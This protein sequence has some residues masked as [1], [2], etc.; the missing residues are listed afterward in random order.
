VS[1]GDQAD[2]LR[3]VVEA[4][5]GATSFEDNVFD[6]GPCADVIQGAPRAGTR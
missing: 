3:I 4:G 2:R 6:G 5:A 1:L